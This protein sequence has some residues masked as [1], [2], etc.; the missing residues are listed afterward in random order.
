MLDSGDSLEPIDYDDSI[1]YFILGRD[2]VSV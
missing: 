1:V 2:V